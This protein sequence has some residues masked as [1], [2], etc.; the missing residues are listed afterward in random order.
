M[1]RIKGRQVIETERE[2]KRFTLKK[3][4]KKQIEKNTKKKTEKCKKVE[5]KLFFNLEKPFGLIFFVL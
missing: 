3:K 5:K 4:K 2:N 1:L